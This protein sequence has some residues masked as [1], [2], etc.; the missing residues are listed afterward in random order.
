MLLA[1]LLPLWGAGPLDTLHAKLPPPLAVLLQVLDGLCA[2]QGA[3]LCV[4]VSADP[5]G[6]FA[7]DPLKQPVLWRLSHQLR[8]LVSSVLGG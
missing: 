3:R 1:S 6:R 5:L 7:M 8:R 4:L 2:T